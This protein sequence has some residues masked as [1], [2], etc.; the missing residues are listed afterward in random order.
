MP[1]EDV[2]I[3]DTSGVSLSKK[4]EPAKVDRGKGMDLLSDVA[5]LEAAQLKEP[6][7]KA[8]R[9]LTCFM[10]VAQVMELVPNQRDSNDDRN[11]YDSDDVSNDDDVDRDADGDN[12]ANEEEY[13]ELYKDMNVRLKD[14]KHEGKGDA[15][16][17]GDGRDDVSQEN[18]YEQVEDDAHV[19]LTVALVT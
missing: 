11:D 7:R 10:Q 2:V 19:T 4:K 14:A 3:R 17:T 13:E 16:M 6:S 12:E 15:E 1:T 18:S 5:L 9:T 8:S